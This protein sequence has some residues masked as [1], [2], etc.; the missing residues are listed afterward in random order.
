MITMDGVE[1]D[2]DR[3]DF[4]KK[5]CKID[6]SMCTCVQANNTLVLTDRHAHTVYMY[7]TVKGTSRAVTDGNIQE[8]R[9]ACVGPGDTVMVSCGKK[10]SIVHLSV[11]GENLGTYVV[12]MKFQY[13]V[14]MSKDG[15]KLAVSNSAAGMKKFQLYK[16]SCT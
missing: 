3:V 16:I 4:P 9:Y 14:T 2:F 5:T 6:E 7:D 11:T 8:P 10:T 15:T 1:S 13:S 12:N